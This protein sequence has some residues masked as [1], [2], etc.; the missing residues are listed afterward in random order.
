MSRRYAIKGPPDP[1]S[2]GILP[3]THDFIE[4][5]VVFESPRDSFPPRL[6]NRFGGVRLQQGN[7]LFELRDT[8]FQDL[9][10]FAHIWISARWTAPVNFKAMATARA[11]PISWRSRLL[12]LHVECSSY[13][14]PPGVPSEGTDGRGPARCGT[15]CLLAVPQV[16][17]KPALVESAIQ[18]VAGPA[19]VAERSEDGRNE[20]NGNGPTS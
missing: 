5:L 16:G 20:R 2:R 18:S 19:A 14:K 8:L 7:L 17:T 3:E 6:V 4:R 9:K 13:S 11:D 1:G 15:A 12:T 10:F